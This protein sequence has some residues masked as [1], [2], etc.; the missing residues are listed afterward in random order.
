MWTGISTP[1]S[2][3]EAAH[4]NIYLN[5]TEVRLISTLKQLT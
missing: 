5:N 4:R 1:Q 3:E 2:R